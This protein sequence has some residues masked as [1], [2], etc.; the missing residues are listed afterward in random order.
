MKILFTILGFIWAAICLIIIL[1]M[2][3]GL[4]GFSEQMA[5]LPFMKINPSLSGGEVAATIEQDN[6]TVNIHEPVFA[7]LIGESATG[8]V[9]LDWIWKD[10]IPVPIYD[11]VDFNR[12][13]SPDFIIDI[14]P[15]TDK[16]DLVSLNENVGQ[17]EDYALTGNG[18]IVR[19]GLINEAK[20]N[21]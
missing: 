16:I 7:A 19:I 10:S 12:D 15:L 18:Y 13:H 11:S 6:Y 9:Q 3:P 8:F 14:D 4:N 17:V 20:I 21:K 2:F 5:K 1:A